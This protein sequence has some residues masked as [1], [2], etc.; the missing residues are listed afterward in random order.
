[1]NAS[2]FFQWLLVPLSSIFLSAIPAIE[3]QTRL[4]FN[5]RLEY[6]VTPKSRKS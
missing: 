3:A 2:L 6:Q 4:M 1:M 5:K